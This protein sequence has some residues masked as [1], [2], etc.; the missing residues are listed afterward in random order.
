MAAS[1]VVVSTPETAQAATVTTGVTAQMNGH[2][3]TAGGNDNSNCI[4]FTPRDGTSNR[5]TWVPA[6][7]E[8]VAAHGYSGSCPTNLN[9]DTQSAIGV[10]PSSVTSVTDGTP[11]L[12]STI[13]HYNNPVT[14]ASSFFAGTLGIRLSGFDSAP[15]LNFS[16][17]LWETSN[18]RPCAIPEAPTTRPVTTGSISARPSPVAS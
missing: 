8:A 13:K 5:T 3:G 15:D 12:L 9:R 17:E 14:V 1:L 16:Y 6:G 2:T 18:S 11:F 10:T 7:T 4:R